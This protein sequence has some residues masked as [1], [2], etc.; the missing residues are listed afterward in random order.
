MFVGS[1]SDNFDERIEQ[2]IFHAEIV[3]DNE[4]VAT[5]TK[6]YQQIPQILSFINEQGEDKLKQEIE[7]NY[8]QIKSDIL[9]IVISE[10]ERIKNDPNLQYLLNQ[11]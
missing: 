1:V 3:M 5:E 4:K 10:M 9:N 7:N 8:K 2:K 11:Q 6:A